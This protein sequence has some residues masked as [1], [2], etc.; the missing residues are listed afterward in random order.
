MTLGQCCVKK[1][2]EVVFHN[3]LKLCSCEKL[4]ILLSLKYHDVD[5]KI[6]NKLFQCRGLSNDRESQ[7]IRSTEI[8]LKGGQHFWA[9]Y[10]FIMGFNSY[11]CSLGIST[12]LSKP[13]LINWHERPLFIE[14]IGKKQRT[15]QSRSIKWQFSFTGSKNCEVESVWR[16]FQSCAF[17]CVC[18][19]ED[20]PACGPEELGYYLAWLPGQEFTEISRQQLSTHLAYFVVW[21]VFPEH[22]I[23]QLQPLIS[24]FL[25]SI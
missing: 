6:F 3:A 24:S 1:P 11:T 10:S 7:C 21:F 16:L 20:T 4:I 17:F 8:C 9:L 18:E 19:L 2:T 25:M 15:M 5:S 22:H 13:H 12:S 23:Q 14:N